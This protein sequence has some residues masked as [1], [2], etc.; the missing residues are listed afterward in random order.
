MKMYSVCN[1]WRCLQFH[2][3]VFGFFAQS[4]ISTG[5]AEKDTVPTLLPYIFST[6]THASE[7]SVYVRSKPMQ[8]AICIT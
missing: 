3:F 7:I 5:E 4:E 1:H 8:T 6:C 2:L